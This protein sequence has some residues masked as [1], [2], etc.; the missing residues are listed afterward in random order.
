[1]IRVVIRSESVTLWLF[2]GHSTAP[3]SMLAKAQISPRRTRIR[4]WHRTTP[5]FAFHPSDRKD[6]A[7]PDN[8]S[9]K[10][11]KFTK[12]PQVIVGQRLTGSFASPWAA[13]LESPRP[14]QLFSATS[15][16]RRF[17]N[18]LTLS[19]HSDIVFT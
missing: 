16:K 11:L 1:M 6:G 17:R 9:K 19:P 5:S 12:R 2:P 15:S 3:G 8:P 13:I 4:V 14:S 18:L 10:S 7:P